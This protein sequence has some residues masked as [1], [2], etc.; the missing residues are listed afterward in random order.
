LLGDGLRLVDG[1]LINSTGKKLKCVK[2]VGNYKVYVEPFMGIKNY[3]SL[4]V[5]TNEIRFEGVGYL[6]YII[7]N[8]EDNK[9]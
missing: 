7:E 6:N 9:S 8:L 2:R 1:K 4:N 5:T 3:Y